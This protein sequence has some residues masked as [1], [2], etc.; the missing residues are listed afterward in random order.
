MANQVDD[1]HNKRKYRKLKTCDI[2]FVNFLMSG[3]VLATLITAQIFYKEALFQFSKKYIPVVQ[4][5]FTT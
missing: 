4:K 1:G 3:V 5:L 2:N